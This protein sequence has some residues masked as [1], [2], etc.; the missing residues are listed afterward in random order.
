VPNVAVHLATLLLMF[1]NVFI[2]FGLES[3]NNN[4]DDDDNDDNNN[5]NILCTQAT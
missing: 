4:G 3:N 5:N 1:V 2:P